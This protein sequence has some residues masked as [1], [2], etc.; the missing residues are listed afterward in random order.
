LWVAGWIWLVSLPAKDSAWPWEEKPRYLGPVTSEDVAVLFIEAEWKRL[1][2]EQRNLYKEV[3]LENLTE[4]KPE[5]HTCPCCPLAFGSPQFLNQDELHNHPIP[6]FHAGNQLHPGNPCPEDQ[7][8]SQRPSD[9]NHRGAEAED[10]RVEGGVRPLFWSTNERGALVGFSSL[11]Q[12]PPISSWGG[13]RILEIQLSP[14]QNASSEEVDRIS[15]RAETPGFGAVRFGECALAFNQKSNLF[16]QK[17]VT[18]EKSSD[19]RQSQVCRE[20]G[21]GFSRKSQLIIHQRTHTGEKPYVCGECGR[22]FIVESVLRN[23][24]STHSGEKPYV[25]SHCGRGFS[26]KPY[27]I[28]HQRT[29]TR[30][31]S[32]MCTVCGRGFRE[33]S[34]LIKHQRIHTGD[35]PYVCRDCGRGFVR[36]S[37]LNAHQRIHSDEKPFVCRECGRG[38]RAKSTLLLHQWT[39]SEVKPHVCE[40]CGHG[41]SQKSSLKSHRRTH[42]GEKPYPYV[43]GECGRGFGRKI[44]LNRHWRTHTG[45]KPYACI[46]CGRN[47]SHK[48]TLSLHQRIHSGEKPYACVEC[49]RSFRRKSQLIIHQKIHSGKSFRGAR[50][51][52][53]I[54]ATSQ[55]SATPAEMLREKPCL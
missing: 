54:L 42:S 39:H 27:L 21:R 55:P 2:L 11:F 46:E 8:Q 16:R 6:G 53:V 41:F 4:S 24:L 44:L 25:C 51:E 5:V 28:R 40:E 50:S 19:K 3:M 34:E 38:F 14:A 45:E 15:K 52:D 48:S 12:R 1:R 7:P 47:F 10:Q 36:R 30:E 26:C 32:F 35:K 33:K 43:C 23:H 13:N 29:H 20:C 9:K 18:A 31:K 37:C 22:G 49:G 17:A